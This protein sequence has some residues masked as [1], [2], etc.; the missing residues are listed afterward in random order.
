MM[1]RPQLGPVL[2]ATIAL[3]GAC[4]GSTLEPIG[5]GA[6]GAG[7]GSGQGAGGNGGNG[8]IATA[9]AANATGGNGG[10]GGNGGA[11][12]AGAGGTLT[13]GP[14]AVNV[15]AGTFGGIAN[16]NVSSGFYNATLGGVSVAA[17]SGVNIG[18]TVA[19]GGQ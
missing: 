13:T 5:E 3:L 4:G 14:V 6:G 1:L 15:G 10:N 16:I 2:V 18:T 17:H 8:G 19:A 9:G 11:G 12:G 7:A